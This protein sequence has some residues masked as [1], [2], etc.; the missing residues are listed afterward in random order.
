MMVRLTALA[1]SWEFREEGGTGRDDL[2]SR[3]ILWV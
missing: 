1:L 2:T 3:R